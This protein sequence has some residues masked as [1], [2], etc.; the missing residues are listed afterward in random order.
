MV[1]HSKTAHVRGVSG[2][3]SWVLLGLMRS[4]TRLNGSLRRERWCVRVQKGARYS[5]KTLEETTQTHKVP[6]TLEVASSL[7][8]LVSDDPTQ[9]LSSQPFGARLA[10]AL[11]D[12]RMLSPLQPDPPSCYEK[13]QSGSNC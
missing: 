6:S 10:A 7:P 4:G 12:Y 13:N 1:P 5:M 11:V 9:N 3:A 8:G 2:A